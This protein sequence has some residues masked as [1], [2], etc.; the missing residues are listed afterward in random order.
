MCPFYYNCEEGK[1]KKLNI[2]SFTRLKCIMYSI[3]EKCV[4]AKTPGG[5]T[6]TVASK[7]NSHTIKV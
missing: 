2:S 5:H 7:E 3:E 6:C 1:R 4:T